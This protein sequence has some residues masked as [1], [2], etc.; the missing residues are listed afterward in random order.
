MT[1]FD[2]TRKPGN[3]SP[4]HYR[5]KWRALV[6]LLGPGRCKWV[7]PEVEGVRSPN[8]RRKPDALG[9]ARSR[10]DRGWEYTVKVVEVKVSRSDFQAGYCISGDLNYV[11]TPAGLVAPEELEP[12][13]G[14][15][16]VDERG[17]AVVT[18]KPRRMGNRDPREFPQDEVL[19]ILQRLS[20]MWRF[21]NGY[22]AKE[23]SA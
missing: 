14:L 5:L 2:L 19:A 12:G 4:L 15:I 18:R 11:M 22:W 1:D 20:N 13:V 9:I 16:E 6:W 17:L 7:A 8:G 21:P 23:E 3:E 10:S